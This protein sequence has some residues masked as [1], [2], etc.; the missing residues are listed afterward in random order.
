MPF[1]INLLFF[2]PQFISPAGVEFSNAQLIYKKRC[3]ESREIV[4]N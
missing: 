1:E 4:E 3:I 2:S